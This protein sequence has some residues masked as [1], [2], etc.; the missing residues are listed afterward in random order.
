[1]VRI[2]RFV[3]ILFSFVS[4]CHLQ[5]RLSSYFTFSYGE[6]LRVN[7]HNIVEFY[8]DSELAC[9]LRCSRVENCDKAIFQKA[10]KK[11]SWYQNDQCSKDPNL[12]E[13][14]KMKKAR[15]LTITKVRN[16]LHRRFNNWKIFIFSNFSQE[17]HATKLF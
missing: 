9:A 2:F 3:I 15:A 4:S 7:S 16:D 8:A 13:N 10:Y 1:M 17:F 11:C 6:K 5:E 12:G 14:I